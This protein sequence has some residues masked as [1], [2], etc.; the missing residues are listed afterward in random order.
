MSQLMEQAIQKAR[1]LPEGD[2]EAIGSIIL[3]EIESERRWGELFA[4]PKSAD[5]LSRMADEA[6]AE[7]ERAVQVSSTSK[8][9]ELVSDAA[10][11]GAVRGLARACSLAG[12]VSLRVVPARSASSEPAFPAGPSHPI[13]SA[14]VGLH[15]RA[16]GIL[17][18]NDIF[19]FWIG[20][21]AEY[22]HLLGQR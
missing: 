15:Y 18:G 22:D 17:E 10:V 12:P 13:F 20:S 5:L 2:Q 4:Q 21:H 7:V 3:Q 9:Y 14:R 8:S 19:W 6:L 1:Q 11:L 16:V